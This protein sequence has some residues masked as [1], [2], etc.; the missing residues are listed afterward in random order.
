MLAIDCSNYT[1]ELSAQQVN[2]LYA[3]GV[4]RAI[5]QTVNPSLLTH[6]QQIPVLKSAGM[7]V[8]GYVYLWFHMD[9]AERV[10]WA[11]DELRRLG[12]G[13]LWLDCEDNDF[14]NGEDVI[15]VLRGIREAIEVAHASGLTVGIYTAAW[16]WQ[17]AAGN[18]E[19]FA[20]LPLWVAY[21]DGAADGMFRA[22]GGWETCE[23]KQYEGD[24]SLAGVSGIDLNWYAEEDELAVTII[25]DQSVAV[26]TA[27]AALGRL[28]EAIGQQNGQFIAT[29]SGAPA[30]YRDV[31]IRVRE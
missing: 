17:Y 16:W 18:S 8:E 2:D 20:H 1:G 29:A 27:L 25:S 21:Y 31:V 28:S 7:E 13:H 14:Q 26:Q 22:F 5:V 19:E 12:I 11:C 23:L 6:R 3:A 30:G 9:I 15:R 10:R 24:T 4:R